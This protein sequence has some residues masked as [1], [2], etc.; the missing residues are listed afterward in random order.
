VR[1]T[2]IKSGVGKL[3]LAVNADLGLNFLPLFIEEFL[4]KDFARKFLKSVSEIS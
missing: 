4:V 2:P 1:Y 3:T